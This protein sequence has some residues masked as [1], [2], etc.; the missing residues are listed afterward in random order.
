MISHYCDSIVNWVQKLGKK[1]PIHLAKIG[2]FV[3]STG[4]CGKSTWSPPPWT[5]QKLYTERQRDRE[6]RSRVLRYVKHETLRFCEAE[7][8]HCFPLHALKN[9][10]WKCSSEYNRMRYVEQQTH[11]H[12]YSQTPCVWV[13]RVCICLF[14]NCMIAVTVCCCCC[15]SMPLRTVCITPRMWYTIYHAIPYRITE[16][17]KWAGTIEAQ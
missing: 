6:N 13:L 10:C 2:V 3:Q 9:K 15:C 8:F 4:K 5:T 16:W 14:W 1:N 11:T 12:I 7:P 17:I